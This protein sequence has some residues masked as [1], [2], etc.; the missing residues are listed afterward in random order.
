MRTVIEKI[1]LFTFNEAS[2]ALKSKILTNYYNI[3]V[4]HDWWQCTY[5][6]ADNIGVNI[7]G[8]CIDRGSYCDIEFK[9]D[10]ISTAES[11][12][13]EHGEACETYKTAKEFLISLEK[14]S[15]YDYHSVSSLKDEF[16]RS[17]SED[18]RIMLSNG[19]EYLTSEEAII[20]T[21][22]C[23]EYEFTENGKI[24]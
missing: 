3:N 20:E 4:D 11:I 2:E 15:S 6:D 1:D 12:I 14:V 24:Y 16:K 7:T 22:I 21:L 18:Y 13:G 10:A 9:H 19:Y 23:N 5:E 8:F 17:L